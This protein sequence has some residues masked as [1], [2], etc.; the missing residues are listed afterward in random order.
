MKKLIFTFVFILFCGFITNSIIAQTDTTKTPLKHGKGFVDADGDGFNDNAPDHDG[1]GIP[2]GLDPDYTGIKNRNGRGFIDLDGDGI[3]D[4]AA[5]HRL[6]KGGKGFMDL[7]NDG[8]NDNAAAQ[9]QKKS[10]KKGGYGPADGTG[11]KEVK[12]KDGT[13]NGVGEGTQFGN[14]GQGRQKKGGRK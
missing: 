8:V 9:R 6:R 13:G 11:N 10:L 7:N 1:D 2:N 5:F 14:N 3:N 4:N 12:P